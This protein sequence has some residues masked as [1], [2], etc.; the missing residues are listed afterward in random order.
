MKPIQFTRNHSD[1]STDRGFQFK[2]FCDKCEN[3]FVSPFETSKI[4]V[5]TSILN[6]VGNLFGGALGRVASTGYEIRRAILGKEHDTAFERAV[7]TIKPSFK[8]CS[9]CGNWVCAEGCWNKS[10]GLCE[11]CAPNL[12]EEK[13]AYEAQAD[14]D[15]L[16]AHSKAGKTTAASCPSCG[17]TSTGGKFCSSCGN[18]FHLTQICQNC[19][20]TL[21]LSAAFCSEC[22]KKT[23]SPK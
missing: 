16:R 9:R 4:G 6:T 5:G 7:Q 14:V 19:R 11:E 18:A 8:N 1:L 12:F 17:A 2:F 22:G 23:A 15:A 21:P 3:G 20:S 10:R 13:A